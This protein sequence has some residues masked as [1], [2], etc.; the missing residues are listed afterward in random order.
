VNRDVIVFNNPVNTLVDANVNK[1]EQCKV[2]P[3]PPPPAAPVNNNGN[4]GNAGNIGSDSIFTTLTPAKGGGNGGAYGINGGTGGSGGGSGGTTTPNQRSLTNQLSTGGIGYGNIGGAGR[5]VDPATGG[6]GGSGFAGED[7]QG[8]RIGGKGGDGISLF[9]SWGI[10][11]NSGQNVDGICYFAGGG[12]GTGRNEFLGPKPGGLGGGGAGGYAVATA[13]TINTGGGG[14]GNYLTSA[15][16]G[17]S[18]IIILRISGSVTATST[19]GSPTRIEA[20]GF[21]YYKFTG[22]GSIT[23]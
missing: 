21:T 3:P 17:G 15:A 2:A 18:G 14:G 23:F 13:G 1:C 7:F 6:G 16:A 10:D 5:L 12:G 11:T 9:S 22:T 8:F 4:N 19:T 20:N